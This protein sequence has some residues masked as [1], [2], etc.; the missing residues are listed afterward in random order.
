[1]LVYNVV[2]LKAME[3]QEK[4]L[5]EV[6]KQTKSQLLS[7]NEIKK[8]IHSYYKLKDKLQN[9][10]KNKRLSK[11]KSLGPIK[12][13]HETEL[14]RQVHESDRKRKILEEQELKKIRD[15]QA[16]RKMYADQVQKLITIH[17]SEKKRQQILDFIS[18][19]N[20]PS[21]EKV[22]RLSRKTNTAN[23]IRSSG[24]DNFYSEISTKHEKL[25]IEED[26]LEPTLKQPVSIHRNKDNTMNLD[27][28]G[29]TYNAK[30]RKKIV[31]P[32]YTRTYGSDIDK[33]NILRSSTPE[34]T[35]VA[36]KY[37]SKLWNSNSKKDPSPAQD[38]NEVSNQTLD[39]YLQKSSDLKNRVRIKEM[40]YGKRS[41]S[42]A[43]HDVEEMS[44]MLIDAILY[45]VNVLKNL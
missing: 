6:R 34:Y 38:K 22:P 18:E 29:P 5:E 43:T 30:K 31:Q 42:L 32:V 24:E 33:K 9:Q 2:D 37:K 14:S 12:K 4:L 8:E 45:K 35:Y 11:I 28:T 21:K 13:F 10:L 7:R 16:K 40:I 20:R 23:N 3:E 26:S 1:M 44:D 41:Q 15:K 17:I 27:L 25:E 39:K 19:Q 36:P